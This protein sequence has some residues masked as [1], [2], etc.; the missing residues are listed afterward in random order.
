MI[1]LNNVLPIVALTFLMSVM[2]GCELLPTKAPEEQE[3]P[4]PNNE[5]IELVQQIQADIDANRLSKPEGENAL[6]RITQLKAIDPESQHIPLLTAQVAERYLDLL[7]R[8]LSKGKLDSANRYWQKA[9]AL[10]PTLGRLEELAIAITNAKEEQAKAAAAAAKLQ[11][12][13]AE[14]A[15]PATTNSTA[16]DVPV[17]EDP[18]P[19]E[20]VSQAELIQTAMI[21]TPAPK[22]LEFTLDQKLIDARSTLIGHE[23]DK[24]GKEVIAKQSQVL[25]QAKSMR[26]YRWLSAL[27][28]TSVYLLDS[29]FQLHTEPKIDDQIAPLVQLKP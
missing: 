17:V 10:D 20:A 23:L 1:R 3:A 22:T 24:V 14:S 25:I 26:D 7:E 13:A 12:Q 11:Q 19:K 4:S 16:T 28:K 8:S 21:D 2:S 15:D 6:D 27:L 5:A 18:T 9:N 29:K